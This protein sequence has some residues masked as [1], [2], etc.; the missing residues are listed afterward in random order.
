ML[1]PVT[2]R[3]VCW[4]ARLAPP[5]LNAPNKLT[6]TF[7]KKLADRV[8]HVHRKRFGRSSVGHI[9]TSMLGHAG[10][11]LQNPLKIFGNAPRGTLAD[12][13]RAFEIFRNRPDA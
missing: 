13:V 9:N 5:M 2:C 10:D 7:Q 11:N 6:T 3:P 12:A 4:A 8:E 1:L